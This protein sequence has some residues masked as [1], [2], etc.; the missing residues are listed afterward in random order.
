MK[1]DAYLKLGSPMLPQERV[2]LRYDGPLIGTF[3]V[4]DRTIL[5]WAA[6]TFSD[7]VMR[8]VYVELA[9]EEVAQ[10]GMYFRRDAG[11]YK[12][13]PLLTGRRV[14]VGLSDK[15]WTLAQVAVIEC[16]SESIFD[17]VD[18]LFPVS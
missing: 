3:T 17:E 4:G 16:S 2:L 12:N 8:Y 10:L 9:N 5:F 11:G 15:Q 6:D 18:Q 7:P 13:H 14:V 1:L